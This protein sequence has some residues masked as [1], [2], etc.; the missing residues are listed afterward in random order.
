M[1]KMVY[2]NVKVI[3]DFLIWNWGAL[4]QGFPLWICA[5]ASGSFGH[6]R[7]VALQPFRLHPS[8]TDRTQKVIFMRI[9]RGRRKKVNIIL[10]LTKI[11]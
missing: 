9:R 4:P 11:N 3:R 6:K 10:I 2:Y 5:G 1:R 8:G 7:R